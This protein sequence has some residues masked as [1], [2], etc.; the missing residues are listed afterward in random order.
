MRPP[1]AAVCAFTTSMPTPRP[2][3]ADSSLAVLK[4]GRRSGWSG[5][6]S[7]ACSSAPS[8]P[9]SRPARDALEVEAGAVVAI[10]IAI[11]L[12]S[13]LTL[14][15]IW[16]VSGLPAAAFGG[17]LDAVGDGVAQQV[18]ERRGHL[19]EHAAVDFDAPAAQVERGALAELRALWRTTR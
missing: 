11:S 2:D 12:P 7:S 15:S 19:F 9:R 18:L 5:A 16:P 3:T 13:W 14:S 6:C 8:R 4:P 17:R 10:S 1:T